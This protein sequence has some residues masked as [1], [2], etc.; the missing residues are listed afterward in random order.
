MMSTPGST[1][2]AGAAAGAA[3]GAEPAAGAGPAWS[4]WRVVVNLGIVSLVI[5]LASKGGHSLTGAL[6]GQL[7]A[8]ALIVGVV[9]GLGEAVALALRLVSGPWS[10]K[11][12]RYWRFAI[13]GY[14]LTAVCIPLL[15]VTPF[16]G[17]A[18]L[19]LASALILGDRTGK[20]IRSPAKTVLL[21]NAA[22]A[23]GR[24]RGFGVHKLLDQLGSLLGPLLAWAVI[25]VT[26][27][28][29]PAFAVLAIPGAAG[30]GILLWTRRRVPD[31]NV[32]ES[33]ESNESNESVAPNPD[34]PDWPDRANRANR[35]NPEDLAD[36]D[37]PDDAGHPDQA[38]RDPAAGPRLPLSFYLLAAAVGVSTVGLVG[39]GVISFHLTD[40]AIV[41]L[42]TV[43]LIYAAAMGAAALAALVSGYA[44]DAAGARVLLVLPLLVVLVPGLTLSVQAGAVLAGALIWGAATGIQ[45][46][47]VQALIADL[48]PNG[49]RGTAYGV[50]A[51]FAGASA[52]IGG[53]LAGALYDQVPWLVMIVGI[54]QTC[55]L[56]LFLLTFRLQ[57]RERRQPAGP[58]V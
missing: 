56:V 1:D 7:G 24:G 16:V 49:H 29:W 38:H 8:S 15:A 45:E 37:D 53:V 6:L 40:V 52:L 50:F 33:S 20:A 48:V 41:P 25:T 23:V 54:L 39:F 51:A 22:S 31:T 5:D 21:A 43:P 32:Y 26:T 13:A 36:P 12:V 35:A 17:G 28:L 9:T 10:D 18:G 11:S 47:T 4:A 57:N 58:Q 55:A 3:P 46:S 42:A 19:L 2:N 44:Y 30:L 14:A 34:R 27:V